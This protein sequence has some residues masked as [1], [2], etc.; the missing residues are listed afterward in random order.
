LT[1]NLVG[2]DVLIGEFLGLK[3]LIAGSQGPANN[4]TKERQP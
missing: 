2:I 1:V 3:D 4:D